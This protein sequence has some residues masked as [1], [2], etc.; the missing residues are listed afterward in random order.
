MHSSKHSHARNPQHEAIKE[1][2]GKWVLQ[3]PAGHSIM[4]QVQRQWLFNGLLNSTADWKIIVSRVV[5]NKGYRTVLDSLL[6]IGKGISPILGID[7]SGIQLSTGLIG[8]GI[9]SD[10]WAGFPSDQDALLDLIETN[11]IK[12]VFIVSGDA[13]TAALDDGANSGIPELLSANLKKANSQDAVVFSDFLGYWVW[14]KGASGLSTQNLNNTYGKV[15]VFGKDSIRLSAIDANGT[16]VVGH[17][18]LYEQQHTGIFETF[19]SKAFSIYPNPA[20]SRLIIIALNEKSEKYTAVLLNTIGREVKRVVF[21]RKT[22]LD[23]SGLPEGAYFCRILNSNNRP[24]A[25][26]KVS[27]MK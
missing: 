12:N 25:A 11:D 18:F 10:G 23:I 2:G 13:H 22:E 26:T 4:G 27:V 1:V 7:V 6:K 5:F 8:A 21:S 24:V 15:E 19:S 20:S 16:E 3:E 9:M 17:T 14:N